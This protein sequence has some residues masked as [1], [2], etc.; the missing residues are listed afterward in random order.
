M[1]YVLGYDNF[2]PLAFCKFFLTYINSHKQGGIYRMEVE[3][4]T[5]SEKCYYYITMLKLKIKI[6]SR[7]T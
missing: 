1:E 6:N 7:L 3:G 4:G 2:R 5:R